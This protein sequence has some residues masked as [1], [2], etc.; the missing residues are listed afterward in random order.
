M[1]HKGLICGLPPTLLMCGETP[2]ARS[3]VGKKEA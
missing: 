1:K 3:V 2:L